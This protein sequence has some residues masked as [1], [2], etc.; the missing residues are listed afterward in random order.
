[1]PV[2]VLDSCGSIGKAPRAHG[3]QQASSS[4]LFDVFLFN[5]E[6]IAAEI[7]LMTLGNVVD[8]FVVVESNMTL[9]GSTKPYHFDEME[10]HLDEA[11][12]AKI[13]RVRVP[14]DMTFGKP[15]NR[16]FRYEMYLRENVMIQIGAVQLGGAKEGDLVIVAD[17]DEIPKPEIL[18]ALKRDTCEMSFPVVLTSRLFYYSYRVLH[19]ARWGSPQVDR[20]TAPPYTH[21]AM[22][23]RSHMFQP[24]EIA[25]GAWHCSWCFRSITSFLKKMQSYSHTEHN[26]EPYNH[27]ESIAEHVRD[28]RD[29]FERSEVLHNSVQTAANPRDYPPYLASDPDRFG[30]FLDHTKKPFVYMLEQWRARHA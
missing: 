3:R 20:V 30:H 14:M 26:R 29:L 9:S 5:D 15:S 22:D 8:Y 1:M 11:F 25:D 4:R 18:L 19:N 23:I 6:F 2:P 24:D 10:A 28:G 13:I 17:L 7:R 16:N 21:N 27:P 12:R